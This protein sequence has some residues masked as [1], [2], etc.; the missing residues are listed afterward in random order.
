MGE[1]TSLK[2][3]FIF[4]MPGLIDENFFHSVTYL[5]EHNEE[6]AMGLVIN[7]PSSIGLNDVLNDLALPTCLDT[8]PYPVVNGGPVEP[9]RGFIIHPTTQT[10]ENTLETI[11]DISITISKDILSA[12]ATQKGPEKAIIALGYAGWGPQQLE[13]EL[14]ANAWLS[15]PAFPEL[16]FDIPI[17]KRWEAAANTLGIDVHQLTTQV[18]H[19]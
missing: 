10:W 2:N 5:F 13:E 18:G 14:A 1:F 9:H 7:H 17:E 16:M 8:E 3:H 12:I 6:G 11:D 15:T 4:A 19:G